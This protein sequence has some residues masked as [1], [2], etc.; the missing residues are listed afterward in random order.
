MNSIYTPI[1]EPA[2][3][4]NV[5]YVFENETSFLIKCDLPEEPNGKLTVIFL[6]IFIFCFKEVFRIA[7]QI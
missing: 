1:I 2:Q 4:R 5:R 6:I 3:V 7:V